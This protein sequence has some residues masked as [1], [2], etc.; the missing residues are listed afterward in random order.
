MPTYRLLA[1]AA[2]LNT[3]FLVGTL[4]AINAWF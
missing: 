1:L 2:A 4:A 3:T